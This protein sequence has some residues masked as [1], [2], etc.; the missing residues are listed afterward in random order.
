MKNMKVTKDS[1]ELRSCYSRTEQKNPRNGR[2]TRKDVRI[3]QRILEAPHQPSQVF[4]REKGGTGGRHEG[5][6]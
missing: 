4:K 2:E 3:R 1:E 5:R 6:N